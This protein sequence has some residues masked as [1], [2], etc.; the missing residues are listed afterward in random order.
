MR[1]PYLISGES[2][3]NFQPVPQPRQPRFFRALVVI[4]LLGGLSFALWKFSGKPA[5]EAVK[6]V[7]PTSPLPVTIGSDDLRH[8]MEATNAKLVAA[9]A[10]L[11]RAEDQIS[12]AAATLDQNY[13][14]VEKRRL[15]SAVSTTAEARRSIQQARQE[16][17]LILNSIKEQNSK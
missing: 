13:L 4:W 14:L 15:D 11:R 12:K 17:D 9:D 10:V 16:V 1:Q 8:H 5:S 7:P 3:P 6:T 2:G